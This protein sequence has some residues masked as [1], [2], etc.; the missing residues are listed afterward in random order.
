MAGSRKFQF[1][2]AV[3]FVG[4]LVLTA[5]SFPAGAACTQL[6][7]GDF[8]QLQPNCGD[9]YC[10]VVS[11]GANSAAS[12]VSSFW[13]FANG[14]PQI[15]SGTD[16]GSWSDDVW[17]P[18]SG[19]GA[20]LGG[21]WSQS[22]SIDG[23]IDNQIAPGKPSEIMVAAFSDEDAFGTKGYFAVAAARRFLNASPEFD[24]T[25]AAGGGVA[26]D[27][28][29]V[30]IPRSAI[31][32]VTRDSLTFAGP[33]LAALLTRDAITEPAEEQRLVTRHGHDPARAA[34]HDPVQLLGEPDLLRDEPRLR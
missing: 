16:N 2:R 3:A 1:L 26:R 15:G 34:G 5:A 10:Y 20:Y 31:T 9:A 28:A 23:C 32:I 6:Q 30:E 17:L 27:I 21:S 13:S 12:V 18:V 29:L 24:F 19:P 8:G 33:T 14:Q 4:P 25:F 7:Y 22:P 11:P